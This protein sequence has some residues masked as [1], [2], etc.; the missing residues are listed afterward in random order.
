MPLVSVIVPTYN[1]S[2]LLSE[3]LLS[4]LNQT[5]DD[6]DVTVV[7]D[8]SA[9]GPKSLS[10][11]HPR[12]ARVAYYYQPNA[13]KAAARN[14]GA[15]RTLGDFLLFIDDDDLLTQ[16][17]L[18]Y[19][20]AKA[21]EH[22]ADVLGGLCLPFG[23]TRKKRIIEDPASSQLLDAE[24]FFWGCQFRTPGQVL[25]RRGTFLKSGGFDPSLK[26][27]EDLDLYLRLCDLGSV[28]QHQKVVLKYR[29]HSSNETKN[30]TN[31]ANA[32]HRVLMRNM[33]HTN[34]AQ[35]KRL[36]R[37]GNY[38]YR[39]YLSR[40]YILQG[41]KAIRSLDLMSAIRITRELLYFRKSWFLT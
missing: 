28:R 20:V 27:A 3:T 39:R 11:D 10:I 31:I 24:S 14:T 7:D 34:G 32:T 2:A 15:A 18:S 29:I 37:I 4:V 38:A 22:N 12:N 26:H 41:L 23:D 30:V 16:D 21:K 19:L 8:G 25:V 9:S 6:Y 5:F 36:C 13:G 17:A 33:V 40:R 1:R 35:R